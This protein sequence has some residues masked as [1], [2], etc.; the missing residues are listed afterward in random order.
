LFFR[1]W[2]VR[3]SIPV[4]G[5]E[6]IKYG[7]N[8]T[9]IEVRGNNNEMVILDAG[10]GIYQL[11]QHLMT[12]DQT[13]INIFISHTHWDHIQGLPMFQPSFLSNFNINIFGAVDLESGLGIKERLTKQMDRHFFPIQLEDLSA[14]INFIDIEEGS[15]IE[16]GSLKISSF[17]FNHPIINL[18][19]RVEDAYNSLVFTGDHEWMSNDLTEDD[20]AWEE[21]QREVDFRRT[22]TFN[23]IRQSDILIIDTAYTDEEYKTKKGWGHGTFDS[24]IAAGLEAKCKQIYF[25]HHEPRRTDKAL[26]TAFRHALKKNKIPENQTRFYL[27]QEGYE[28]DVR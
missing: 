11:G 14:K 25:T 16:I 2:G 19:Y 5:K 1:F 8:T 21:R 12:Q 6:T 7:G 15:E 26:E 23:F 24:S 3:G 22:E 10:T 20:G 18:G 13:D 9:C 17:Q 28:V 4:P 27:A